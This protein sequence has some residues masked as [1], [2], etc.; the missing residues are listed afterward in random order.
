MRQVRE[1][2]ERLIR[3]E[4]QAAL[5][6]EQIVQRLAEMEQR[7]TH[8]IDQLLVSLKLEMETVA[9]ELKALEHDQHTVACQALDKRLHHLERR[10]DALEQLLRQKV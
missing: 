8:Q 9:K 6:L 7:H 3:Q 1:N 10:M 2:N 5:H 4:Q